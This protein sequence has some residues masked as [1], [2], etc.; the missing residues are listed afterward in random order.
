MNMINRFHPSL[1]NL[2][3]KAEKIFTSGVSYLD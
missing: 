3:L 1:R 2:D